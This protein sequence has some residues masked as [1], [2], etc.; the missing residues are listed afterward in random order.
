MLRDKVKQAD[1]EYTPR[2]PVK[3]PVLLHDNARPVIVAHTAETLQQL[4]PGR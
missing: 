2:E 4:L 3:D 1:F